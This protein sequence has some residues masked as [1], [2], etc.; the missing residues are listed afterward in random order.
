MLPPVM[1][2]QYQNI[3][4][5][6]SVASGGSLLV[7]HLAGPYRVPTQIAMMQSPLSIGARDSVTKLNM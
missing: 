1:W 2:N 7:P 6:H 3:Q 5:W 4:S